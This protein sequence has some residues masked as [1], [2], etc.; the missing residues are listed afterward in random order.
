MTGVRRAAGFVDGLYLTG[1]EVLLRT[2][3][4]AQ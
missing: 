3:S 4:V 2:P 1:M